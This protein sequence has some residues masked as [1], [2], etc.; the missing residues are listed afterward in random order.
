MSLFHLTLQL[1]YE[2]G[3]KKITL[4]LFQ[5]RNLHVGILVTCLRSYR[6]NVAK[7]GGGPGSV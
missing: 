2:I 7:V 3:I 1:L 4:P 6:L 5:G